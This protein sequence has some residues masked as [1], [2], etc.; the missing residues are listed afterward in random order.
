MDDRLARREAMRQG[1]NFI[2]TARMLHMA[3]TRSL[4]KSAEVVVQRM[5]ERG[6]RITP[7][8]LRQLKA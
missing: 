5:A 8:L 3:E 2:G 7:L 4:I 6:Y 1:V